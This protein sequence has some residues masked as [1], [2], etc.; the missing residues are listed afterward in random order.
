MSGPTI[1]DILW[2]DRS[3]LAAAY[4]AGASLAQLATVYDCSAKPIEQVLRTAGVEK[5]VGRPTDQ[6]RQRG[7]RVLA[8]YYGTERPAVNHAAAY[9]AIARRSGGAHRH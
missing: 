4:R 6:D 5:R 7:Q 3:R 8:R 2:A 1:R 9:S